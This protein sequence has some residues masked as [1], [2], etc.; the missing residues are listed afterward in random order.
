[1][2][3]IDDPK[4]KDAAFQIAEAEPRHLGQPTS[5]PIN[6]RL[7]IGLDGAPPLLR[8]LLADGR[9]VRR[10]LPPLQDLRSLRA[11]KQATKVH[12]A[13]VEITEDRD[14]ANGEVWNPPPFYKEPPLKRRK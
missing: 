3:D 14:T 5:P 10:G 13:V 6:W 12:P 4:Y 1:M 7:E 11:E 2:S 9:A 8:V